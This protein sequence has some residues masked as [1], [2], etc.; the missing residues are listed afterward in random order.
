MEPGACGVSQLVIP[1][2]SL[3]QQVLLTWLLH[4]V[5]CQNVSYNPAYNSHWRATN[6]V[7]TSQPVIHWPSNPPTST[8]TA[9]Q[10]DVI[11]LTVWKGSDKML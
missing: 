10:A 9:L 5:Y 2:P 6:T 3:F 11:V 7:S 8:P 1:T 4:H